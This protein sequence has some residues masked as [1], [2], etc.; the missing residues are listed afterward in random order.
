LVA[1]RATF[2]TARLVLDTAL[3]AAFFAAFF[4]P[5]TL[6][7]PA[8]ILRLTACTACLPVLTTASSA[9]TTASATVSTMEF[10]AI[11]RMSLG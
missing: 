11:C 5:A 3:R 4:L 8:P 1:L 2:R 9:R 7:L 6:R 10:F